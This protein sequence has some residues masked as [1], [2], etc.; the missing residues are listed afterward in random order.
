V[1]TLAY[2]HRPP[3]VPPASHEALGAGVDEHVYLCPQ[4]LQKVQPAMDAIFARIVARDPQACIVLIA[5]EACQRRALEARLR[6]FSGAMA[7]RVRFL[8]VAP[9]AGFL[10]RLA[11][12]DVVLDTVHFN[13]QNTTLESFAQGTPVVTLPGTLQRSRHGYGLYAAGG[14]T[15]LVAAD[16]DD[17]AAK[18]VRVAT[19]AGFRRECGERIEQCCGVLFDDRRFVQGCAGAL[20]TLVAQRSRQ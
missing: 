6:A 9:Y 20:E 13:G 14:F 11:G 7:D 1:G 4:T 12:A 19:D 18:A 8:P 3:R 5:F 17:Y 16:E 15:E 2:Y 10:A